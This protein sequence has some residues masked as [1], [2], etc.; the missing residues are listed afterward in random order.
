MDFIDEVRTRSGRFAT[1]LKQLKESEMTEEATKT[2]FVLPFIQMIG[3]DIFD[4][5]NLIPE[6]TADIGTKKGEKVDYALIQ[7]KHP[8]MLIECKKYGTSLH[9]DTVSQLVRYFGV[10]EARVGILTDGINYKFFSDL[11]QS[12]VMDPRPFFEFNILDFTEQEVRELKRFTKDE[13]D[14]DHIIDAAKEL[15]YASEI[16]RLLAKELTKPSDAFLKYV[17]KEVYEGRISASA[18]KMFSRLTHSAFNQF[19]SEKIQDRLTYALKQEDDTAQEQKEKVVEEKQEPEFTYDEMRAL[20]IIKAILAGIV[21]SK[22]IGLRSN[23]RYCSV[24]LHNG[25]ELNDFGIVLF[26]LSA[27]RPESMSLHARD[28]PEIK[29]NDIEDL[30]NHTDKLRQHMVRKLESPEPTEA[31]DDTPDDISINTTSWPT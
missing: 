2:S 14:K 12:N 1:R 31:H 7:N 15:R 10:T 22:C 26:R 27:R 6:F 21:D 3:Y 13:F 23:K 9:G 30:F 19:V 8:V 25:P 17:M 28:F 4:P 11:D 20:N 5:S 16:K 24:V 18:R 29:L